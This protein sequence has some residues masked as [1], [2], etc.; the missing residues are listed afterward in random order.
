MRVRHSIITRRRREWDVKF[1]R[2]ALTLPKAQRLSVNK[3]ERRYE[4]ETRDELVTPSL[5][6]HKSQD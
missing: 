1:S 2:C 3:L 4:L 5:A 6:A